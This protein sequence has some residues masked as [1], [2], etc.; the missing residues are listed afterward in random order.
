MDREAVMGLFLGEFA[1]GVLTRLEDLVWDFNVDLIMEML[2]G[3]VCQPKTCLSSWLILYSE[4]KSSACVECISNNAKKKWMFGV[5]VCVYRRR[6]T[7][8]TN[9]F[10]AL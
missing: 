2:G 7:C 3:Y 8:K 10:R 9:K 1:R 4:T 5:Y 6:K